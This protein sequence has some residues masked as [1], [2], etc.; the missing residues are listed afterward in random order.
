MN[1]DKEVLQIRTFATSFLSKA[2]PHQETANFSKTWTQYPKWSTFPKET[3]EK[4]YDTEDNSDNSEYQTPWPKEKKHVVLGRS[5]VKIKDMFNEDIK[6]VQTE[7]TFFCGSEDG[8]E[9]GPPVLPEGGVQYANEEL[10]DEEKS[11][12]IGSMKRTVCL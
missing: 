6:T 5:G 10:A 4:K 7:E 11:V 9:E 12:T 1:E 2:G 3:E 8:N